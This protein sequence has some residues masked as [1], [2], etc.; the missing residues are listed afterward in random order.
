MFSSRLLLVTALLSFQALGAVSMEEKRERVDFLE[1]LTSKAVSMNIDAYKR[2]LRYEELGLPLDVRAMNEANLLAE[3]V[4]VQVQ[5]AYEAALQEKSPN[6]A[7]GEVRAAIVKDLELLSPEVREEIQ[8][9]AFDSLENINNASISSAIG[10]KQLEGALIEEIKERAQFL[11]RED[12]SLSSNKSNS[13]NN[14]KS[15]IKDFKNKSEVISALTSDQAGDELSYSTVTMKSTETTKTESTISLKVSVDFLG[16]SIDA[17]P[18]INFKRE[19]K[20][21]VSIQADGLHPAVQGN[22]LF[23]FFKR[24][25]AGNVVMKNGVAQ[26]RLMNFSC[27]S[28]LNFETDY[29]G[30]GGFSFA[31]VGGSTSISKEYTNSVMI[32]SRKILVPE[33]I[34]GKIVTIKD[35]ASLCHLD[36]LNA[37]VSKSM[38]IAGSLNIMMKN[39]VSGLRFSHP[40]TKCLKDT[41]CYD[42]YNNE[43]IALV[44]SKNFPRCVEER[45]EK[46]RT[47]ELRGLEGQN[48]AVYDS[49]GKRISDGGF[50]F[51]CDTGLKCVK[52]RNEGWFQGFEIY[53]YAKGV[54]KPV[55]AKT[56]RSP[57]EEQPKYYELNFQ[58]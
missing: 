41:Q 4:R 52:V 43:I 54:C 8:Q 20:T 24:D 5:K 55:N 36:F 49:K 53:Q 6:E 2:D 32:V 13:S 56:Y 14:Q 34:G 1:E 31:G 12:F 25:N 23:D 51:A 15:R 35:L 37:K 28:S 57:F 39:I 30:S 46:Y 11:N 10:L 47:C 48:C 42:W 45:K 9:I 38:T 26:K 7:I 58:K 16:A 33:S 18:S 40:K 22:G 27:D 50:E 29:T 44:R 3:K 21:N 19:F 17:G